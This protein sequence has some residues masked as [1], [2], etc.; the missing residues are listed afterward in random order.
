MVDG[1]L[2]SSLGMRTES[3]S[4]NYYGETRKEVSDKLTE[5]LRDVTQGIPVVIERQTL[6]EFFDRRLND[7]VKPSVRPATFASDDQQIKVHIAPALGH[8]Q[9]SRLA[10]S[11]FSAT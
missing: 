5:V 6:T 7:C 8:L 11:T 1:Y 10:P 3:R 2:P 9:L 4:A